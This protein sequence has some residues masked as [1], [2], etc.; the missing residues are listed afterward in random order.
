MLQKGPVVSAGDEADIL[1]VVLFGGDEA[2]GFRN[3][4]D[5][6][7]CQLPQGEADVP[8]LVLVKAGKKIGLVLGWVCRLI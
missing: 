7:L 8:E 4:A 6:C 2:L 1:A 5:L 3:G